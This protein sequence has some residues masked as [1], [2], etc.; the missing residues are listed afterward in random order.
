MKILFVTSEFSPFHSGGLGTYVDFLVDGL[1]KNDVE[2][3]ILLTPYFYTGK[4]EKLFHP[5]FDVYKL[6]YI[7]LE[8][9]KD[10]DKLLDNNLENELEKVIPLLKEKKFDLIHCHEWFCFCIGQRLKEVFGVKLITTVHIYSIQNYFLGNLTEENLQLIPQNGYFKKIFDI[11]KQIFLQSDKVN[12]VSKSMLE[13]GIKFY[14]AQKRKLKTIYPSIDFSLPK[15][16]KDE[17]LNFRRN[18]AYDEEKIIVCLGRLEIQ[19]GFHFFIDSLIQIT[20]IEKKLKILIIGEGSFEE[21]LKKQAGRYQNIIQFL[22]K[23]DRLEL[24]KILMV[25]DVGVIPSLYEPFGLV[26]LEMMIC[27]LPVIATN[28]GGLAEIIKDGYNGFLVD[29]RQGRCMHY[30]NE[31]LVVDVNSLISKTLN[32]LMDEN[33]RK[34]IKEQAYKSLKTKFSNSKFINNFVEFYQKSL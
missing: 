34:T 3:T 24:K 2:I 31:G 5:E 16:K 27:K 29:V 20:N 28:T 7:N 13:I 30:A 22:G 25:S 8:E 4:F 19:K 12:F 10:N 1:K 33:L 18:F 6:P 14:N 9:I 26:A 11:E 17:F 15:M 32:L 23:L 21:Y